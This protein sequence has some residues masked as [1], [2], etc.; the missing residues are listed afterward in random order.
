MD[1]LTVGRPAADIAAARANKRALLQNLFQMVSSGNT[2][3]R[4]AL[5]NA[6]RYFSGLTQSGTY[7]LFGSGNKNPSQPF[8]S[9]AEGGD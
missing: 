1:D 8:L 6:G 4:R 3:L 5:D 9:V 7:G 2:P